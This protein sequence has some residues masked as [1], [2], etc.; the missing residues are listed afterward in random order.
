MKEESLQ[1]EKEEEDMRIDK[2]S[3]G[4]D[5]V[6]IIVDDRWCREAL[7]ADDEEG[8]VEI[9][10]IKSMA[11]LEADSTPIKINDSIYMEG[12]EYPEAIPL[13]TKRIYAKDKVRYI[14]LVM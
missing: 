8:W 4:F 6:I 13:K 12:G 5:N 10:D 3:P 7:A 9:L 2:S 1:E 11:P 14:Q